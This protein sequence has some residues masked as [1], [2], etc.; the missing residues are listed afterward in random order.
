MCV[1]VRV[2]ARAYSVLSDSVQPH[3]LE[4]CTLLC[5]WDFPGKNTGVGC[6]FLLQGIFLTQEDPASPA[7][8]GEFFTHC[9]T[10]EDRFGE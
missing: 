2:C 5:P 9:A 3:G 8:A 6:D 1:C 4:S 10:W 7:L